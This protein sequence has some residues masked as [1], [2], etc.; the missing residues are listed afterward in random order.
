MSAPIVIVQCAKSPIDS[1][2]IHITHRT[3]HDQRDF[4]PNDILPQQAHLQ[5]LFLEQPDL[6]W[7]L[8]RSWSK[9]HGLVEL[10]ESV[11]LVQTTK[12]LLEGDFFDKVNRDKEWLVTLVA[13]RRVPHPRTAE[14]DAPDERSDAE[15]LTQTKGKQVVQ[16]QSYSQMSSS[17]DLPIFPS[18]QQSRTIK[19]EPQTR[20]EKQAF[21]SQLSSEIPDS[22]FQQDNLPIFRNARESCT[23]KQE[24][25]M[26]TRKR[27]RRELSNSNLSDELP[28]DLIEH[29]RRKLAT[30]TPT[31]STTSLVQSRSNCTSFNAFPSELSKA[32]TAKMTSTVSAHDLANPF[33]LSLDGTGIGGTR[34]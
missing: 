22:P 33:K 4:I 9:T 20:Q 14:A 24:P 23:I 26:S 28:T 34:H 6:E 29:W 11:K 5:D 18:G 12:E 1:T 13:Q 3:I 7:F 31:T 21:R 16:S 32:P 15:S 2:T 25:Q 30:P 8:A 17:P 27:S 19:Q 10:P